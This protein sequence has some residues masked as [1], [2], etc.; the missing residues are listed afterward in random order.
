MT[1][2][3]FFNSFSFKQVE[4]PAHTSGFDKITG[5]ENIK[6]ILRHAIAAEEGVNILLLGPPA[7]AK[8][9]F[10]AAVLE[11]AGGLWFDGTNTSNK[12]LTTLYQDR[13]NVICIDEFEK[14]GKPF[15]EKLLNFAENGKVDVDQY[16]RQLHFQ[17]EGVKIFAS[18]NDET[19]ISKPMKSRFLILKMAEYTE[20]QFYNIAEKQLP[21]L[22][23]DAVRC[24]ARYVWHRKGDMRDVLGIGRLVRP[25]HTPE[26]ILQLIE[27]LD[28]TK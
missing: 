16:N 23:R 3:N 8:S 12:I 10:L 13:P 27:D 25:N 14:M 1:W 11:E 24:I 21:R 6:N 15:Q 22:G 4:Q 19:R 2:K 28:K 5:H 26:D 7:S 17:L 9:L 18:A 20:E